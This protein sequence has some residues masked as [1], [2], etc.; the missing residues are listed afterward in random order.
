MQNYIVFYLFSLINDIFVVSSLSKQVPT[1]DAIVC[2]NCDKTFKNVQGLMSHQNHCKGGP[3]RTSGKKQSEEANTSTE[4]IS[5][6]TTDGA[7][8]NK[9]SHSKRPGASKTTSSAQQKQTPKKKQK[10]KKKVHQQMFA[11]H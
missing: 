7:S 9:S 5:S 8:S 4:T 10:K 2:E 1:S 3:S 11:S 6:V